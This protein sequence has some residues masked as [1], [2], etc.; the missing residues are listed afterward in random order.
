MLRTFIIL[1]ALTWSVQAAVFPTPETGY[2]TN[3]GVSINGVFLTNNTTM[4]ISGGGGANAALYTNGLPFV[5]T[6]IFGFASG[7]NTSLRVTNING[8]IS[9]AFDSSG[10]GGGSGSVSNG[11]TITSTY[12]SP[13]GF[14]TLP[15][16]NIIFAGT[17]GVTVYAATNGLSPGR[18]IVVYGLGQGVLSNLV[19][20]GGQITNLFGPIAGGFALVV[21]GSTNVIVTSTINFPVTFNSNVTFNS[22]VSNNIVINTSTN[23]IIGTV[24]NNVSATIYTTN[25]S[26]TTVIATVVT[27]NITTNTVNTYVNVNG[28]WNAS[29]AVYVAFPGMVYFTG[30]W[31]FAQVFCDGI[32]ASCSL[33]G[34]GGLTTNSWWNL[35]NGALAS[36]NLVLGGSTLLLTNGSFTAAYITE[37]GGTAR[38][39]ISTNVTGD[40]VFIGKIM[41]DGS[42]NISTVVPGTNWV[43]AVSNTLAAA[44]SGGGYPQGAA[45]LASN[46]TF[47]GSTNSFTGLVS[48]TGGLTGNIFGSTISNSVVSNVTMK[49]VD[50][51]NSFITNAGTLQTRWLT[52]KLSGTSG[53]INVSPNPTNGIGGLTI[54]QTLIGGNDHSLIAFHGENIGA[55]I[56]FT[57]KVYKNYGSPFS[58]PPTNSELATFADVE[59]LAV[60]NLGFVIV[61]NGT[62]LFVRNGTVWTPSGGVTLDIVSNNFV[63][64][65]SGATLQASINTKLDAAFTNTSYSGRQ[66]NQIGFVE[67]GIIKSN[68]GYFVSG[69]GGSS[70]IYTN[71]SDWVS[72]ATVAAVGNIG[73]NNTFG[74]PALWKGTILFTD[75]VAGI[76]AAVVYSRNLSTG[77]TNDIQYYSYAGIAS[78]VISND[79]TLVVCTNC[80]YQ[81]VEQSSG[82]GAST[83]LGRNALWLIPGGPAGSIGP[84]GATGA[85]GA[86]G[87]M[88]LNLRLLPGS[89]LAFGSSSNAT[90]VGIS[91][92][93]Y[94]L[95]QDTLQFDPTTPQ[96]GIW[97]VPVNLYT[98]GTVR[99]DIAWTEPVG[100]AATNVWEIGTAQSFSNQVP[101]TTRT[102][103][104]ILTQ[105][106]NATAGG[107]SIA[108]GTFTPSWTNGC[109]SPGW[110]TITRNTTNAFDNAGSTSSVWQAM[111]TQ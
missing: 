97:Q 37:T 46:N 16:T 39:N 96:Q 41:P 10:G 26:Y 94:G 66:T 102:T 42:T 43:N 90:I 18:I 58:Q 88:A 47:A 74:Q 76:G 82:A 72:N 84:T 69:G 6:N 111:V 60:T 12:P 44:I 65:S 11:I 8:I 83:V 28:S 57:E 3:R 81:I 106:V 110:F 62:N 71:N 93:G 104:L 34:G 25:I 40:L 48:A 2:I 7:S 17:S 30:T 67:R 95:N 1:L 27:N 50:V 91:S 63:T 51:S 14:G 109:L 4:L 38:V 9:F 89:A 80:S 29:N 35:F 45:M 49:V 5:L 70:T 68:D 107:I 75:G 21:P 31:T 78:G 87:S 103:G 92:T 59:S 98:G 32:L 77:A 23:I 86:N 85:N 73:T 55:E 15:A 108:T 52:G 56:M 53:F 13:V 20:S 22:S 64:V 61:D 54:W 105:T 19:A 24:T 36:S 101:P 79:F 33:S 99:V 100:G